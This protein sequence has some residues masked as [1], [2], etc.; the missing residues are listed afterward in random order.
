M[1]EKDGLEYPFVWPFLFLPPTMKR[2]MMGPV[3]QSVFRCFDRRT[4][5][6]FSSFWSGKIVRVYDAGK[7]VSECFPHL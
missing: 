1:I 5:F 7:E 4:D 2:R 6:Q 3:V